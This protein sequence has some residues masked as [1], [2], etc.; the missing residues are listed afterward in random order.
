MILS[1]EQEKEP[2]LPATL[3]SSGSQMSRE[4]RRYTLLSLLPM[5]RPP[6]ILIFVY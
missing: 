1:E 6:A 4:K 3:L 2:T 5:K